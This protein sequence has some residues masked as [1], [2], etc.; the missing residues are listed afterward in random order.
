MTQFSSRAA[1]DVACPFDDPGRSKKSTSVG[2][3]ILTV[4][5][6]TC[7]T[8]LVFTACVVAQQRS[9][10]EQGAVMEARNLARAVAYGA[11]AGAESLQAYVLL[12][13]D[14]IPDADRAVRGRRQ[15]H[16]VLST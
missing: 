5:A 12:A 11:T 6:A 1:S 4:V 2:P 3:K 10:I 16:A 13:A 14:D 15:R 9:E 7:L 8:I